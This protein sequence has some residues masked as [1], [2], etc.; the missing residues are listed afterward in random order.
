MVERSPTLK[1]L[2]LQKQRFPPTFLSAVITIRRV[3]IFL[4]SRSKTLINHV[5]WNRW[6]QKRL[7]YAS[8]SV[9][10]RAPAAVMAALRA[11]RPSCDHIFPCAA[12]E[13]VLGHPILFCS[14]LFPP[15]IHFPHAFPP[16]PS[17]DRQHAAAHVNARYRVFLFCWCCGYG[18]F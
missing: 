14:R 5:A 12:A 17:N 15:S 13:A 10:A 11:G 18:Y 7:I 4:G 3:Q 16:S 6:K 8:A 2:E 1:C 9:F